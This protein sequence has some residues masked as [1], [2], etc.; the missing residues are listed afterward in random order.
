M[1]QDSLA[2][3]AVAEH[4]PRL[5]SWHNQCKK[6]LKADGLTQELWSGLF[7]TLVLKSHLA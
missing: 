5:G 7:S 6:V 4:L 2:G 1:L 3:S